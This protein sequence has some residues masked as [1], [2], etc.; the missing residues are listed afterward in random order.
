LAEAELVDGGHGPAPV[1]YAM[2]VLGSGGRGESLLAMDQDNAIVYRAGE[3]GGQ[4]DQWLERLGVRVAD[5]LSSAGLAYCKGGVMARNS[6]WRMSVEGW[7]A[8]IEGWLRRS[9][10][11]DLM[12]TDIFFDAVPV[13]GT[14]AL[15]DAL[16][17]EALEAAGRSR[18]FL[19]LMAVN[20]AAV[21]VPLGWLGR[22]KLADRR[23]D[24]KRGGLMPIFSAARVLALQHGVT[25]RATPERLKA[26][27]G[28]GDANT[29][30][31]DRLIDAHRILLGAILEQQLQDLEAGIKLSNR[32][33][34]HELSAAER[35]RLRWALEQV[36]LVA[37]VLGDPLAFG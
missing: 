36:N 28:K 15:G 11:E 22:F 26:V 14:L 19:K 32:V 33:A 35:D 29:A 16:R 23:M 34:P 20:A 7:R 37:N 24:L 10:P 31:V 2:L 17:A 4:Q 13:H 1:D 6:E 21:D 30:L 25:A 18:G 5:I 9:R 3:P 8:A 27:R 12:S